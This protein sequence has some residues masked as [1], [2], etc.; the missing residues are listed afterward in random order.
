RDVIA[1][2]KDIDFVR[3]LVLAGLEAVEVEEPAEDDRTPVPRDA[4]E[5]DRVVLEVCELALLAGIEVVLPEV[6]APLLRADEVEAL[7]VGLPERPPSARL[8]GHY[9]RELLTPQ[10]MEPDL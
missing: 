5:D 6:I 9:L 8:V 10:I 1:V 2:V 4:R 7:A 3:L